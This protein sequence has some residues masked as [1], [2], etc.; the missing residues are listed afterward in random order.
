MNGSTVVNSVS[1]TQIMGVDTQISGSSS[2]HIGG[3]TGGN[4]SITSSG[5]NIQGQYVNGGHN[6]QVSGGGGSFGNSFICTGKV[7]I[8]WRRTRCKPILFYRTLQ[9]V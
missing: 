1:T 4:I 3:S 5:I 2:I 8:R 7:L 6:I 9:M